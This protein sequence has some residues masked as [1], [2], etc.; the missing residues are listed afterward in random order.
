MVGKTEVHLAPNEVV[1]PTPGPNEHLP[2]LPM[3][4]A[5]S[6]WLNAAAT[7]ILVAKA[8]GYTI[9]LEDHEIADLA[10]TLVSVALFALSYRERQ[11]PNYRLKLFG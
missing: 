10:T 1:A 8:F 4:L 2:V 3:L 7:L 5:R 6:F 11:A 9:P